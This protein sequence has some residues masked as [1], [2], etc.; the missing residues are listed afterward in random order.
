[1]S[2]EASFTAAV[3]AAALSCTN[4]LSLVYPSMAIFYSLGGPEKPSGR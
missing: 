2:L 1:M 4:P 3:A